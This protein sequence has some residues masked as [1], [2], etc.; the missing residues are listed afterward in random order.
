M[1]VETYEAI[2][3]VSAAIQAANTPNFH[4]VLE[5]AVNISQPDPRH[6]RSMAYGRSVVQ[7]GLDY[8]HMQVSTKL[9]SSMEVFKTARLFSPQ[10][11]YLLQPDSTFV[12]ESHRPLQ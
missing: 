8:F 1:A 10:T 3:R 7:P 5:R 6:Q 4:A 12:Q 11:I 9:S 2:E